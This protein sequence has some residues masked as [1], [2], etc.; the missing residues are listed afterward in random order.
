MQFLHANKREIH[1][2]AT[3]SRAVGISYPFFIKIAN[4]LKRGGLLKATHGRNGGYEWG[5][6]GYEISVYDVFLTMEGDL[7]IT[8]CLQKEKPCE[9]D[10]RHSCQIYKFFGELQVRMIA[11]MSS[12][13]IADLVSAKDCSQDKTEQSA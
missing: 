10:T 11:A 7:C 4:H 3:I 2:A 6:S 8:N 12:T 5:R 13:V 9:N 1:P